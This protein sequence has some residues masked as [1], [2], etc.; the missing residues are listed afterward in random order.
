MPLK[1][2]LL[3]RYFSGHTKNPDG[4][5]QFKS[6]NT[7]VSDAIDGAI[8][9]VTVAVCALIKSRLQEHA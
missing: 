8:K 6:G 3:S 7:K 9:I 4:N 2:Q 1:W 5:V